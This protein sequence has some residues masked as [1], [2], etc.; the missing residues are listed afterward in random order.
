MTVTPSGLP[1]WSRTASHEQYGGN[2]NK[3]NYGGVGVVDAQ[4]D[5]GAEDFCRMAS[6]VAAIARTLPILVATIQCNDTSPAAPTFEH[7]NMM[8]GVRESSYE[9]DA[10]PSGYPTASRTSAGR[11]TITLP[12]TMTDEYGVSEA[13]L[14]RFAS[15]TA[16]QAT[17]GGVVCQITGDQTVDVRIFDAAGAAVTDALLTLEIG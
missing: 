11:F 9:G 5:V 16:H 14:V 13:P 1:P 6:D 7:I 4:T 15:G 8:T 2:V 17:A 12:A 3:R 10:A